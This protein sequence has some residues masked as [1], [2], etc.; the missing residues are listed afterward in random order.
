MQHSGNCQDEKKQEIQLGW[1][2][3]ERWFTV[4]SRADSHFCLPLSILFSRNSNSNS[5]FKNMR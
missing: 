1:G 4:A 3:W 2:T 5:A